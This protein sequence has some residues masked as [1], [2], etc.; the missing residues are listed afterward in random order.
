M[1]RFFQV[2]IALIIVVPLLVLALAVVLLSAPLTAPVPTAT[3]WDTPAPATAP[4]S[5]TP[6]SIPDQCAQTQA[7]YQLQVVSAPSYDATQ[8]ADSPDGRYHVFQTESGLYVRDK[9]GNLASLITFPPQYDLSRWVQW[10]P[11]SER[12]AVIV[13]N[14][15]NGLNTLI[16]DFTHGLSALSRASLTTG[17]HD[18]YEFYGW[19]PDGRYFVTSNQTL[20]DRDIRVWSVDAQ[21]I[22]YSKIIDILDVRWSSDSRTLAY[23]WHTENPAPPNRYHYGVTFVPVNGGQETTPGGRADLGDDP[24]LHARLIWSPDHRA[25]I[26]AYP[27]PGQESFDVY[28]LDG[29]AAPNVGNSLYMWRE[30]SRDVGDYL[31]TLA[32]FWAADSRSVLYWQQTDPNRYRLM[33]WVLGSRAPVPL[34]TTTRPPFF[35]RKARLAMVPQAKRMAIYRDT[36]GSRPYRIDLMNLDG[37]GSVNFIANAYDAGDPN[38][39]GDN[40]T[41]AAVWATQTN[42]KRTLRLSWANADGSGYHEIAGDY[43]DMR[44]LNWSPDYHTFTFVGVLNSGFSVE[45]VNIDSGQHRV[46]ANGLT[47]V[48]YPRYDDQGAFY[49][50]RWQAGD[51][52]GYDAYNADGVRTYRIVISGDVTRGSDLFWSPDHQIAAVKLRAADGEGL[53]LAVPGGSAPIMVRTGLSGLGNPVWSPDSQQVAF[54]QS[55]NSGPVTL[56]I[57]NTHGQEVWEGDGSAYTPIAWVKCSR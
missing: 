26:A 24:N 32:V 4:P 53:Q 47:D 21:K 55:I 56:H 15:Q 35:P 45:L 38:W 43:I 34:M 30:D 10:S 18:P 31:G 40:Q 42:G 13:G 9:G 25:V 51:T 22:I 2:R 29:I 46:L 20:V 49:T 16:I 7:A 12:L 17:L 23:A 54:T 6:Y 50:F 3:V 37:T 8:T 14:Y 19:S 5:A 27:N 57:V 28:S 39:S 41:V 33:R 44:N 48:V 11:T 1:T 52:G 36:S